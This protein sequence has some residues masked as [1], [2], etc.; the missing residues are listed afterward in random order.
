MMLAILD[1]TSSIVCIGK[2]VSKPFKESLGVREGAVESPHCFNMY[3]DGL[4]LK[5]ESAHP[6][7]CRLMGVIVAV[8]LYAD[9]AALP[10]DSAEDLQ[11]LATL[12]EEFCNDRRLF[13]ATPKTFVT[14][15]HPATD[16]RVIYQDGHVFVDGVKV[17]IKIYDTD[18]TAAKSFKYLGV[19]LDSTCNQSAHSDARCLS[20][21]RSA[22][23]LLAGLSRI[24]SFPH[25][26]LT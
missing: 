23:L 6:R 22:H 18:I 20:F 15:F 7:L 8:L 13:I 3:V 16:I 25:K 2:L 19:V 26:L 17:E 10:A 21:D 1:S 4:R 14:V 9:D 24:P 12:F 11:L 5:L